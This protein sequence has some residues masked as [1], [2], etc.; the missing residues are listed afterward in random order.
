MEQFIFNGD[1]LKTGAD[2][3]KTVV[4]IGNEHFHLSRVLR[5]RPGEKVLATDGCGKTL[6]CVV[7]V[8]G[9]GETEC[10]VVEEFD[11]LNS[12]PREFCIAVSLL[13]PMSKLE[14]ALEKCT[15]LGAGSFLLFNSERSEKIRPRLDRLEGIIRSAVKQSLRSCLPGL[16]FVESL[17]EAAAFGRSY[18]ER[19]VL[20]EKSGN[21]IKNHVLQMKTDST[22]I[23]LIGPE[24]GFSEMEIASLTENGYK[25]FSLG[26]T[27]LRSETAAIAIASLL[28]AC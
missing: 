27:R 21:L 7:N 18:G 6:L 20:H 24:G 28:S 10:E 1:N 11:K 22:A 2:G 15:E 16:K 4:L 9:K 25:D 3:K 23:A 14:F 26:K 8:I 19:I 13:K 5:V 12:P 17:A